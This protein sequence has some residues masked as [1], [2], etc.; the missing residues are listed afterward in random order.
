MIATGACSYAYLTDLLIQDRQ[1]ILEAERERR[2]Q[3]FRIPLDAQ[4]QRVR[5]LGARDHTARSIQVYQAEESNVVERTNA[6]MDLQI[7][8]GSLV[9]R[10]GLRAAEL[11]TMQGER[12]ASAAHLP[13]LPSLAV[14]LSGSQ[15][16]LYWDQGFFLRVRTDIVGEAG[17]A[18]VLLADIELLESTDALEVTERMGETGEVAICGQAGNKQICFPSRFEPAGVATLV[19]STDARPAGRALR[20]ERG[21]ER[22]AEEHGLATYSSFQPIGELGLGIVVNVDEA[23]LLAPVR[24]QAQVGLPLLFLLAVAGAAFMRF[25]LKPLTAELVA[26]RRR[27]DAEVAS[28]ALAN[29][30]L[31]T[32]ADHASF[33]I[34]FVD[35]EFVF[36][37]A[38]LAHVHWFRRPMDQI[39]GAPLQDLVG[40]AVFQDYL[41]AMAS[42][43]ATRVPQPVFREMLRDG[44]SR[45][46]EVTFVAQFDV[47]G[48]HEGY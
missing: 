42:A 38:N 6:L 3:Q 22:V 23:E 14:R 7:A 39:V 31:Q 15:N 8:A 46:V 21:T 45:F 44:A 29:R 47:D 18:G 41:Q 9:R 24:R 26:A 48:S 33:L 5:E 25:Q 32:I 43:L 4:V 35:P 17:T 1:T 40:A 34:A 16:I 12:I 20:G 10:S 11:Q 36:R 37:F 28:R 27:A 2:A 13:Q 19:P 30:R